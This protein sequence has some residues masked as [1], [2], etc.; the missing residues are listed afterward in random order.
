M[1]KQEIKNIL[2][3]R[4]G[5]LGDTIVALPAMWAV[6]EHFAGAQ[7]TLL[8]DSHIGTDY[9]LS[10]DLL[11]KSGLF[12]DFISYEATLYMT[13]YNIAHNIKFSQSLSCPKSV[14]GILLGRKIPDKWE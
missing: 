2:V 9:V 12:D 4:I 6:R 7:I 14:W 1:Q 11:F 13:T 5:Q 3:F 8:N 10:K